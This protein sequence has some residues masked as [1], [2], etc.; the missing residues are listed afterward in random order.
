ML[1]NITDYKNNARN[2]QYQNGVGC[3]VLGYKNKDQTASNVITK[4]YSQILFSINLFHASACFEHTCSSAGGQNLY[5][6]ASG[7]F[8]PTGALPVH[9]LREHFLNLCM[10]RPPTGVMIPDAV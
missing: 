8:T 6:I 1:V 9:R 5:Y 4:L 3:Y 10:G 7:I 2:V